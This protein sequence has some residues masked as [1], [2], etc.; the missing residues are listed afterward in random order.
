MLDVT[1]ISPEKTLYEG[2]A[3]YVR[4]PGV[5][6]SFGVLT[7]HA[8]LVALLDVG[9]IEI[10]KAN[11][12]FKMVVDGGFVEVKSNKINVMANGGALKSE[13]DQKKV[14]SNLEKASQ[15]Q[16]KTKDLEIKKAKVRLKLLENSWCIPIL[17]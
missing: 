1:V 10:K 4:L 13:L 8:P 16:E 2:N 7:N 12:S 6:G 15:S 5:D 11:E 9:I 14:Q 17:I 3:E